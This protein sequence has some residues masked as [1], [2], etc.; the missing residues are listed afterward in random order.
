[1]HVHKHILL[2][3]LQLPPVHHPL[4]IL[5]RWAYQVLSVSSHSFSFIT[6]NRL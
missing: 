5:Q 3:L 2:C 4:K 1:V 6:Q